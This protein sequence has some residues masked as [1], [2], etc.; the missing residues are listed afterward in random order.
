MKERKGT[1]NASKGCNR[2]M[3]K[4]SIGLIT[5]LA[6]ERVCEM[7]RPQISE[8]SL[9]KGWNRRKRAHLEWKK[10]K[11]GGRDR[12]N[13]RLIA[14]KF[15]LPLEEEERILNEKIQIRAREIEIA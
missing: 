4:E 10:E 7:G 3:N 11:K 13:M 14:A 15:A 9:F 2:R 12:Q 1:K 8:P 5:S 6:G